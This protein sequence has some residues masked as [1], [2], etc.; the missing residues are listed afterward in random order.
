MSLLDALLEESLLDSVVTHEVWIAI[1]TDGPSGEGPFGAGTQNDPYDGSTQAK[2]D[3]LMKDVV[4]S[5]ATIRLGPGVYQTKGG[6]GHNRFE[7][8]WRPKSGQ[9]IIGSGMFATTLQ[10]VGASTDTEPVYSYSLIGSFDWLD[11]FEVSDLTL[12]CNLDGQPNT[13]GYRFPRTMVLGIDVRGVRIEIRRVRVVNFG[14]RVPSFEYGK[15]VTGYECFAIIISPAEN[16]PDK[17]APYDCV[18]EDCI[19]EQPSRNNAELISCL[20]ISGREAAEGSVGQQLDARGCVIRNCLV[21]GAFVKPGPFSPMPVAALTHLG[22]TA[23]LRTPWP[24]NLATTDKIIVSGASP[25]AYNGKFSISAIIDARTLQYTML[26]DPGADATGNIT[27]EKVSKPSLLVKGLSWSGAT[28]T[29]QTYVRHNREVNDWIVVAGATQASGAADTE[30]N[31]SFQVLSVTED[32]ATSTY[33]LTYSADKTLTGTAS[34]EI[35]LDKTPSLPIHIEKLTPDVTENEALVLGL[36]DEFL[37]FVAGQDVS[38]KLQTGSPHNRVP[39]D[40][41]WVATVYLDPPLAPNDY[42]NHP[43]RGYFEVMRVNNPTELEYRVQWAPEGWSLNAASIWSNLQGL[44]NEGGIGCLTERNRVLNCTTG[45][46]HDTWSTKDQVIRANYF[47]KVFFGLRKL[48]GGV[49][50]FTKDGTVTNQGTS[51]P[52]IARFT[53]N[54]EHY[55][56][57]GD[58][59][60]ISGASEPKFNGRFTITNVTATTFD[61]TMAEPPEPPVSGIG[62][63]SNRLFQVGRVIAQDNIVELSFHLVVSQALVPWDNFTPPCGISMG[64]MVLHQDPWLFDQ[65]IAC[66]NFVRH[67]DGAADPSRRTD[68]IGVS[69][70]SS[71]NLIMESNLINL[72]DALEYSVRRASVLSAK[73]FNN[74]TSSG[75]LKIAPKATVV[76]D[77][78]ITLQKTDTSQDGLLAYALSGATV[79]YVVNGVEKDV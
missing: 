3:K 23:T 76:L 38:V 39:G 27:A 64:G 31:G 15:S 59:V 28:V 57:N 71:K 68:S 8:D 9:R 52:N 21:D 11:G 74:Q 46:Y 44:A 33:Q 29:L 60:V 10:F 13:T 18:I 30:L 1:R 55:Y 78:E 35:W 16:H 42:Y 50:P 51:G 26:T 58:A 36:M 20:T 56:S 4:P 40:F 72:E 65:V 25:S 14:T 43:Y 32:D 22:T 34:G 79:D 41:V 77:D 73:S 2:F 45:Y 66:G 62:C 54:S 48:M 7:G 37:G 12:D 47:Y 70:D 17:A 49:S 63:N 6:T 75:N 19:I 69:V 24:H 5:K 53:S 67:V 61:Y